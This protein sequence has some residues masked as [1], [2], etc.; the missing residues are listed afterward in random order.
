MNFNIAYLM[1]VRDGYA[2]AMAMIHDKGL[3][4]GLRWIAEQLPDNPHGKW[5]LENFATI[6]AR[7]TED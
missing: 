1:G 5:L 7:A 4:E 3:E 2:N 6:T